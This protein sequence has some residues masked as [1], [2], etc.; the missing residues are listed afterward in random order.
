MSPTAGLPGS[1]I[2]VLSDPAAGGTD[3]SGVGFLNGVAGAVTVAT[4][5]A[6]TAVPIGIFVGGAITAAD[7]VA[8]DVE[9]QL[10]S[11]YG[12]PATFDVNKLI[13]ENSLDIDDI[14]QNTGFSIRQHLTNIGLIASE[15]D[16][17]FQSNPLT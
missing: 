15:T 9:D 12:D 13:L 5:Q 11:G 1:T 10:V 14:V 7:L 3:I 16:E 6:S 8:A 17:I 2:S 4:G